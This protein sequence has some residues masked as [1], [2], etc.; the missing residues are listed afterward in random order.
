MWLRDL[1]FWWLAGPVQT[2]SL[3]VGGR[4]RTYHIHIPPQHNPNEPVPVVLAL[5]AAL[6]NGRVM[7]WFSGLN[8]KADEAG[9][10]VVTRMAP[11]AT[12]P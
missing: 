5:H 8:K 1:L 11:A 12:P 4:K 6:M 3:T 10:I 9:F 2:R 7:A